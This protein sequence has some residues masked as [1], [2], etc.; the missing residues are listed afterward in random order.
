MALIGKFANFLYFCVHDGE[1]RREIMP[2]K[3]GWLHMGDSFE[4]SHAF[5][6]RS[7]TSTHW[8]S[9]RFS[10]ETLFVFITHTYNYFARKF[11]H[12]AKKKHSWNQALMVPLPT[13]DNKDKMDNMKRYPKR[14]TRYN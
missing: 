6:F 7:E 3:Y 1:N 4:F 12:F 2:A 10:R 8:R 14:M 13:K 5:R 9:E 11:S